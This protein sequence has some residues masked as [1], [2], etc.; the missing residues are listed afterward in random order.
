MGINC[1]KQ[2]STPTPKHNPRFIEGTKSLSSYSIDSI[3]VFRLNN[4]KLILVF[5]TVTKGID[6]VIYPANYVLKANSFK[7]H[8][9]SVDNIKYTNV[10]IKT[11]DNNMLYILSHELI[12]YNDS[13]TPYRVINEFN[14]NIDKNY[15]IIDQ[16]KDPTLPD[17][18]LYNSINKI[19]KSKY[20]RYQINSNTFIISCGPNYEYQYRL[21]I[22]ESNKNVNGYT[23]EYKLEKC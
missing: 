15:E 19:S 23:F 2:K 4:L 12:N 13:N 9:L 5:D 10:K 20:T 18:I 16:I 11:D 7:I 6:G 22:N 1:S 8:H 21:I 3:V 17:M 14:T